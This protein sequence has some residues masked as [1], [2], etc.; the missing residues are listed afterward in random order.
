MP[1][2]LNFLN[3]PEKWVKV[4]DMFYQQETVRKTVGKC[5]TEIVVVSLL[6]QPFS[7]FPTFH[8]P[9]FL[10]FIYIWRFSFQVLKHWPNSEQHSS[11]PAL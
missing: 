4:W 2:I 5:Q 8:F 3:N 11:Q 9:I 7:Y 10:L 1:S 6:D